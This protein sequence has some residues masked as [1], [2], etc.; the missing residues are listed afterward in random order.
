ML[1]EYSVYVVYVEGLNRVRDL[2]MNIKTKVI[3]IGAGAS[4][5]SAGCH[6]IK[7]NLNELII[8][9]AKNRIGGRIFTTEFG[10]NE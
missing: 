9:E 2:E 7:N 4:G 3:I 8:L 6:L 1:K 10:K 5:I